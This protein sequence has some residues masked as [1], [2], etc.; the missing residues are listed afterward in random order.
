MGVGL[1]HPPGPAVES[2]AWLSGPNPV[3]CSG[4]PSPSGCRGAA[5][6]PSSLGRVAFFPGC[7]LAGVGR[8]LRCPPGGGSSRAPTRAGPAP[9]PRFGPP[10]PFSAGSLAGDR[11]PLFPPPPSSSRPACGGPCAPLLGLATLGLPRARLGCRGFSLLRQ[12][13]VSVPFFPPWRAAAAGGPRRREGPLP[14]PAFFRGRA[15][16]RFFEGLRRC[17]G[18]GSAPGSVLLS[19]CVKPVGFSPAP[20]RPAAPAGG[21]GERKA[22]RGSGASDLG[23]DKVGSLWYSFCARLVSPLRGP[24]FAV[25]DIGGRKSFILNG[26]LFLSPGC[27][28]RTARSSD[29]RRS[30][31]TLGVHLWRGFRCTP[32]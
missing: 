14:L 11:S 8:P 30:R 29:P 15:P 28:T 22:V 32:S 12:S 6:P 24:A 19:A 27:T 3:S 23:L 20:P 9:A 7:Q 5:A 21:S 18:A 17:G 16:L 13:R 25:R 31:C 4:A 1:P 10:S 2:A 26:F